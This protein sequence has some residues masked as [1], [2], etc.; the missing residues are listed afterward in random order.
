[1]RLYDCFYQMLIETFARTLEK[2]PSTIKTCQ[3]EVKTLQA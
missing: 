2:M 1:M 3:A